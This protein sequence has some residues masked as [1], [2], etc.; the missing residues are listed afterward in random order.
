MTAE[1]FHVIAVLLLFCQCALLFLIGI[2]L[3]AFVP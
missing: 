1:A 2:R 3:G